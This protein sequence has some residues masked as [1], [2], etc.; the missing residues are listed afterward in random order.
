[1][2]AACVFPNEQIFEAGP[3]VEGHKALLRFRSDKVAR[4]TGIDFRPVTVRKG[5]WIV[6]QGVGYFTDP[7]VRWANAYSQK[8]IGVT[9]DRSIWDLQ[10]VTRYIAPEDF[11][12]QLVERFDKRIHWE[13]PYHFA[14]DAQAFD[15]APVINTAPLP[16]VLSH[17]RESINDSADKIGFSRQR[18]H[19]M[20]QRLSGCD[21]HQTIY[22]PQ[23]R[24]TMYRASIT[25]DMLIVE[26]SGDPAGDWLTDLQQSFG[27]WEAGTEPL[28]EVEQRYGKIQ[29]I[30]SDEDRRALLAWLT[31]QHNIYSVGRFATWRNVL[32]DDVV[33]DLHRVKTLMK[34]TDYERRLTQ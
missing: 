28:E 10:P 33:D 17:L 25:G 18:I 15:H 6:E 14:D 9:V 22:Y 23:S 26:F 31:N 1:M 3:Q 20:R 29:L 34:M 19:V 21:V 32:L 2:L 8:V 30:G 13:S 12:Q 27:I 4:L 7:T 24:H 11:Y 5:I 16:I